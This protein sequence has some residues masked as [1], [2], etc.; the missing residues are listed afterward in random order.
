[1]ALGKFSYSFNVWPKEGAGFNQSVYELFRAMN[2]RVQIDFTEA[3]FERFRYELSQ[4]GLSLREVERI[5][6]ADPELVG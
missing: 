2:P 1:M 6:Y 4:H 3:E 5:P